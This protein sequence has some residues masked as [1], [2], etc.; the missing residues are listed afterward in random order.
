MK[1][2]ISL[3]LA[4]LFVIT[5]VLASCKNNREEPSDSDTEQQTSS[6]T[7]AS[8]DNGNNTTDIPPSHED[9]I[10]LFENKLM[11]FTV[12]YPFGSMGDAQTAANT[13][14]LNFYHKV[15]NPAENPSDDFDK[16]K[17]KE[18]E[19]LIGD[20]KREESATLKAELGNNS[21]RIKFVGN[22]LVVVAQ[23]EW[24]L[25]NAVASLLQNIIY[26]RENNKTVS[27]ALPKNLDI[28]YT[29]GGYTRNRWSLSGFPVYDGGLLGKAAYTD[30]VGYKT[31][32]ADASNYSMIC[33]SK[34]S[35]EEF[36]EYIAKLTKEGYTVTTS[37][38]TKNVIGVWV[39]KNGAKMYAYY[40]DGNKEARFVLDRE[41]KT[42]KEYSYTSSAT[43][44]AMVYL[45]GLAMDPDGENNSTLADHKDP[46][47]NEWY[48]SNCGMSMI[49]KLPDNSVIFIDGGGYVQMSKTAAEKLNSFLHEITGTPTGQKVT[50]RAWYLTHYHGDH[51]QGFIRFILNYHSQYDLKSVMFNLRQTHLPSDL[52]TFL[53]EYLPAYYPN[54]SYH[55]PHTGESISFG[56]VKIDVMFTFEDL[57]DTST[58]SFLSSDDNNTST[59]IKIWVDGKSFL[60]TGDMYLDAEKVL[61]RNYDNGELKCDVLQTPHHGLNNTNKLFTAA[62]PSVSLV[63][64]SEGGAK[65][66]SLTTYNNVLAATVG[67]KNNVYFAGDVT[68]C[69][70]VESGVLTVTTSAADHTPYPTNKS[71]Q[72]EAFDDFNGNK[73]NAPAK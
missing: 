56:N 54:I 61:I 59:V 35:A 22:K 8:V 68:A 3:L 16:N 57:I 13:C 1:K 72:W 34:T 25:E 71:E 49:I 55:R 15:D 36:R 67:G 38:D 50:M 43:S 28:T 37:S 27:A 46:D 48:G 51:Y 31:L 40:T 18:F 32:K 52:K 66:L 7:E 41:S 70:K 29:M 19:I 23:K 9:H 5:P 63:T 12:I 4:L 45:Y 65:K 39:T 53:G 11:S 21:Y 60:I 30:G 33:A 73:I 64:Q 47:N 14:N 2:L 62:S 17:E 24:M 20:T 6:T 69:V 26:V 10:Y 44:G 42:D 58:L